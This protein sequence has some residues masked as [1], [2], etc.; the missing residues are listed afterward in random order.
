MSCK[1][2]NPFLQIKD[3]TNN[4]LLIISD[5]VMTDPVK[6]SFLALTHYKLPTRYDKRLLEIARYN[7][8]HIILYDMHEILAYTIIMQ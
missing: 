1:R 7:N 2:K 6:A 4:S 3:K 5:V 8:G